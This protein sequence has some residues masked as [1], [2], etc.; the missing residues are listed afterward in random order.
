M[1]IGLSV[2]EFTDRVASEAPVPG[3][4]SVAALAGALSAG[5]SGM[6]MRLTL[7]KTDTMNGNQKLTCLVD[8]AARLQARLTADIDRDARAYRAVISAYRM[9]KGTDEEKAARLKAIEESLTEAARVPFSVA[10]AGMELLDL[11]EI[12]VRE[13]RKSA[14]TDGVVAALMARTSVLAALYNVK[15]NLASLKDRTLAD[16]MAGE[17]EAMTRKAREREREILSA[18]DRIMAE[19]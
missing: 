4:G 14:V 10:E 15:I 1:L 2:E 6:V 8:A 12:A 16:S 18:A 5:L 13:G 17:V 19:G 3:G 9:A 11:A 7:E